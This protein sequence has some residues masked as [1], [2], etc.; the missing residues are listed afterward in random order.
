MQ[1]EKNAL[2]LIGQHRSRSAAASAQF[3][4]GLGSLFIK[5]MD[6]NIY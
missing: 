6:T 2:T 3:D 4:Q 5:L 1:H